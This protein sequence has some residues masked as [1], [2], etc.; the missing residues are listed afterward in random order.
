M[1]RL[2]KT[3][4]LLAPALG[5]SQLLFS[6]QAI[7]GG[8]WAQDFGDPAMGRANAGAVAGVNDA[9]A[10]LHNSAYMTELD[11]AKLMIAGGL[12]Y[13]DGEFDLESVDE[14]TLR[15]QQACKNGCKDDGNPG[16]LLG[17]ASIFYSAPINEKFA[18][19]ISFTGASGGVADYDNDWVGRFD[20]NELN[21]VLVALSPTVAYKVNDWLSV[22]AGVEFL[23]GSVDLDF[24]LPSIPADTVELLPEGIGETGIELEDETFLVSYNLSAAIKLSES[25]RLG[26]KYHP[27]I[28]LE[29]DDINVEEP[30]ALDQKRVW[31]ADLTYGQFVRLGITHAY[32]DKLDLH[33]TV[34][35]DDWSAM[36]DVPVKI[37]DFSTQVIEDWEDTY[38]VAVG[39][40]YRYSK[41]WKFSTGMSYDSSPIDDDMRYAQLAI[42][43]QTRYAVGVE[44]KYTEPFNIG[45]QFVM[46]DAGDNKIDREDWYYSGEFKK[47]RAY[48]LMVNANWT[49]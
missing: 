37:G 10:T 45:A 5:L 42:D 7:A 27:E 13:T 44:Y 30:K 48:M 11:S 17:G 16:S 12:I 38:H 36:E 47:N 23:Y 19:G 2:S 31:Q 35:W 39:L 43:E 22:G 46:L 15:G 21:L 49:F 6:Q 34:G 32:S 1:A 41:D 40:S 24:Y 33:M 28:K 14:T 8:L 9:A 25:T 3:W 18:W 29:F 26:I 20:L 4:V